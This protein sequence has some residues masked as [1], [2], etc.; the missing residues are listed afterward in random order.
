MQEYVQVQEAGEYIA[1][2]AFI[3]MKLKLQSQMKKST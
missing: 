1:T 3:S 2:I